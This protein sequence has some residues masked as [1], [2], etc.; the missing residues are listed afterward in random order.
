[1]ASGFRQPKGLVLFLVGLVAFGLWLGPG[2]VMSFTAEHS[3]ANLERLRALVPFFLFGMCLL[4]LTT[5]AGERAIYFSPGEVD[6]LF[7]GPFRRRELI[8]YKVL[9]S[10]I[11][12]LFSAAIFSVF[13]ATWAA[14]WRAAYVGLALALLFTQLLTMAF[15]LLGQT[16][17]EHAYTRLRKVIVYA[18]GGA[19][20]L[21]VGQVVA[22]RGSR[23]VLEVLSHARESWYLQYLLMPF[24]PFARVLT[25]RSMPELGAW[26]GIALAMDLA[27]FGFVVWLDAEYR[28]AAVSVSRRLYERIQRAQ[29]S[30]MSQTAK[31]AP[32]GH[33]PRLPYLGGAGP[34]AWRQTVNAMR[35]SRSIVLFMVFMGI[36]VAV[37]FN[38]GSE[39]QRHVWTVVA[40][41]MV[42][43]TVFLSSMLRFDFRADIEQMD[44]LKMMPLHPWAIVAGQFVVPV[45]LGTWLQLVILSMAVY[46]TGQVWVL[47]LAVAFLPL[48][49]LVLTGAENTMFLLFPTR[50]VAFSPGDFQLFGR[51]LVFMLVKTGLAAAACGIAA[52]VGGIA[53]L[54]GGASV[55][56]F[57]AVSWVALAAEALALI[58]LTAWTFR[59]FDISLDTP[60]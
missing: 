13:F 46:L 49:N 12:V 27:L 47:L 1:M 4:S 51:Q 6:F 25:A 10:A 38:A 21:G 20:A 7:G 2:I 19:A 56:A 39:G 37:P 17:A 18:L 28:E 22:L 53:Y 32:R 55:P 23:N 9:G 40:G 31:G 50:V 36:A 16:M 5:S 33:V 29:R 44:W 60:V 43:L 35:N 59:R 41:L 45:A 54:L 52:L 42:W 48:L 34:I 24:E 15:I 11:N 3:D 8:I 26:A 57:L 30:G 14:S 58:P